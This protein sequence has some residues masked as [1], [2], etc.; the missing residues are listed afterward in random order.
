MILD[1]FCVLLC[2]SIRE[3]LVVREVYM[4]LLPILIVVGG[5]NAYSLAFFFFA[6]V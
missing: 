2:Y 4:T 6:G 5:E 1:W 3:S